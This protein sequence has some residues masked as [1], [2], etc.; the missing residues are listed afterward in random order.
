MK[1]IVYNFTIFS[2]ST[3]ESVSRCLGT[4]ASHPFQGMLDLQSEFAHHKKSFQLDANHTCFIMNKF[5]HV[6]G[7]GVAIE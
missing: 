6:A 4:I 2:Q 1:Y 7:E 5:D 3:H